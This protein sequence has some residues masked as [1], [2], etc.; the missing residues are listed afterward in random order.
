MTDRTGTAFEIRGL[1]DCSN[2]IYNSAPIYMAD[3]KEFLDNCFADR[4]HFIFT[5]ESKAECA[6]VISAYINGLPPRD[7]AKI[8]RLK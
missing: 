6:D 4:F 3:K 2:I 1:E 5:T 8:R 7:A